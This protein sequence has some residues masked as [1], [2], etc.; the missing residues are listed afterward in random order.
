[1]TNGFAALHWHLVVPV[2][3]P[4]RAK[5]RLAHELGER[6]PE[7]ALAFARDTVQAALAA[8]AVASVT[9]V[10]GD[11]RVAKVLT[12]DGAR[13]IDEGAVA[14]L[15]RVIISVVGSKPVRRPTAVLLGDLPALTSSA[16]EHALALAAGYDRAFVPD[17]AGVGTTFLAARTGASLRPRFGTGSA[18]AHARD[19]AQRLVGKE[20]SSLRCDVDS[21]AD[22]I[23]AA[24][25][26]LGRFTGALVREAG[27][28]G[29]R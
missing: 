26:G 28:V 1:V 13:V 8:E 6:R 2:K 27:L 14:E 15:N 9:V 7:L 10:T 18:A 11:E 16:L 25:L 12:G 19:G 29:L 4:W 22:L 3:E 5:S 23:E 17:A 24:E 20:L 21:L